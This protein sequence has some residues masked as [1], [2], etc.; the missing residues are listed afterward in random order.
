VPKGDPQTRFLV[1]AMERSLDRQFAAMASL[2]S[3]MVQVFVAASLVIGLAAAGLHGARH[4]TLGLLIASLVAYVTVVCSAAVALW[5]RDY[6]TIPDPDLLLESA[7]DSIDEL[8]TALAAPMADAYRS[9]RKLMR[10]KTWPVRIALV[11]AGVEAGCI[12]VALILTVT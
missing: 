4:A 6:S 7:Q 8:M 12:G 3:K 9:N 5:V 1:G 11:S 2:D 10:W